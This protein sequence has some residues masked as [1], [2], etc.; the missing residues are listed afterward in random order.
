MRIKCC[1]RLIPNG[2]VIHTEYD[3]DS[4]KIIGLPE[5]WLQTVCLELP[6]Y[7]VNNYIN[8]KA[9]FDEM[10]E[11][12]LLS[13]DAY[14]IVVEDNNIGYYVLQFNGVKKFVR[15]VTDNRESSSDSYIPNSGLFESVGFRRTR[16]RQVRSCGGIY[17]LTLCKDDGLFYTNDGVLRP[18]FQVDRLGKVDYHYRGYKEMIALDA[19]AVVYVD[20]KPMWLTKTDDNILLPVEGQVERSLYAHI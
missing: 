20:E 14:A 1:Y 7:S 6:D 18:G 9:R 2:E 11:T 19:Y 10:C 12:V 4:E 5:K 17:R 16:Q 15:S 3:T 13:D 8:C